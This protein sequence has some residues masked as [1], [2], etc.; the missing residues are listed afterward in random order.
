MPARI[1][2]AT[3]SSQSVDDD[4]KHRAD[5]RVERVFT[6][7]SGSGNT[8]RWSTRCT[9]LYFEPTLEP[10]RTI[11]PG[12]GTMT[13]ATCA[14]A[15]TAASAAASVVCGAAAHDEQIAAADR[16]LG[17]AGRRFA[18]KL[19]VHDRNAPIVLA[20]EPL[21]DLPTVAEITQRVAELE[22]APRPRARR[23]R[24]N[25]GL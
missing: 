22:L 13:S 14:I 20:A 18:N 5:L 25:R 1:A 23:S 10:E 16:F 17:Q 2:S 7:P 8:R 24:P 4:F 3:A 6:A 21:G 12:N 9:P 11:P 19:A 15:A